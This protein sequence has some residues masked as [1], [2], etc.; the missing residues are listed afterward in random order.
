[1]LVQPGS[2]VLDLALLLLLVVA[3]FAI[4]YLLKLD[5][6]DMFVLNAVRNRILRTRN[7]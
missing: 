6:E 1:M 3:Y 2:L 5:G 4:I 7:A